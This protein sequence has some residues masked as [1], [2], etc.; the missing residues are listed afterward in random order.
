MQDIRD[1]EHEELTGS[2]F[3]SQN[4][5]GVVRT[6]ARIYSEVSKPKPNVK[7]ETHFLAPQT[8]GLPGVGI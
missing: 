4:D 1:E 6:R 7:T 3:T 2:V 8:V 5:P